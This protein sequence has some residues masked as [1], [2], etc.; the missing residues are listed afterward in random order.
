MSKLNWKNLLN[1]KCPSCGKAITQTPLDPLIRCVNCDFA[2]RQDKMSALVASMIKGQ[3]NLEKF[4]DNFSEL[5][6]L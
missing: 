1:S 4:A 2:I 5:Q 3:I 6:N